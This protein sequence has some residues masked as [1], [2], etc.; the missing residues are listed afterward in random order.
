MPPVNKKLPLV[1]SS[2]IVIIMVLLE[3]HGENDSNVVCIIN[4]Y[5]I[6]NYLEGDL[7]IKFPYPNLLNNV[8]YFNVKTFLAS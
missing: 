2:S 6:V 8:Y 4:C 7:E 3:R 1:I 5:R